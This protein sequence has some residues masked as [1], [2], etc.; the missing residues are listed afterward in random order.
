[1]T[2]GQRS[3]ACDP[4]LGL[5]LSRFFHLLLWKYLLLFSQPSGLQHSC[6]DF[7][8]LSPWALEGRMRMPSGRREWGGMARVNR[9]ARKS[10]VGLHSCVL[11]WEPRLGARKCLGR[12]QMS[13]V[14]LFFSFSSFFSS[15]FFHPLH[16]LLLP[17][18]QFLCPMLGLNLG[19]CLCRQALPF[20]SSILF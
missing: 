19:P 15:V 17:F 1:M 18:F 7:T 6:E 16:F 12:S 3:G 5:P 14:N 11:L 9:G 8:L 4:P 13:G 20:S 10:R 2:L